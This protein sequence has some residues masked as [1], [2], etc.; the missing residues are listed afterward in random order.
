MRLLI[1]VLAALVA[2]AGLAICAT[3]IA[4]VILK[5]RRK[6]KEDEQA[7]EARLERLHK[8]KDGQ[9]A[10][11][12]EN[13]L[14]LEGRQGVKQSWRSMDGT[15]WFPGVSPSPAVVRRSNAGGS[16]SGS[17]EFTNGDLA[18][19]QQ[20]QQVMSSSIERLQP[21]ETGFGSMPGGVNR[22][23]AMVTLPPARDSLDGFGVERS[24]GSRWSLAGSVAGMASSV[25]SALHLR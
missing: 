5:K 16:V 6:E 11:R 15:S 12:Q 14:Q 24:K 7:Q 2:P 17:D 8:R 21:G 18:L 10:G 4:A 3:G 13:E 1:I 19:Q 20:Q 23:V 9:I 25:A 22:F